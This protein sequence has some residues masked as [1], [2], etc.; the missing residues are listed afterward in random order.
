MRSS[1][2]NEVSDRPVPNEADGEHIDRTQYGGGL[3]RDVRGQ[4]WSPA[5]ERLLRAFH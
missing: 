3:I 5:V 1:V 2:R 4:L